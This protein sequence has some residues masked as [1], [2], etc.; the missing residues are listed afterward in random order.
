MNPTVYIVDDDDAMRD[1][2]CTL[3]DL[4]GMEA[5]A[6]ESA[7]DFLS[8]YDTDMRHHGCLVLDIRMWGMSG[9]ELQKLLGI[10]GCTLPVIIITGHGDVQ[11]T[12][13]SMKLGAME[14][15]EKPFTQDRLLECVRAAIRLSEER[16]DM[17]IQ[18]EEIQNRIARL[19]PRELEVAEI[20]I[21]G[22]S[23]KEIARQMNISSR[24]VEV[25]RAKVMFKLQ[26]DS[27]CQLVRMFLLAEGRLLTAET[28]TGQPHAC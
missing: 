18:K 16:Y 9:L 22:L 6:Y 15:I 8:H 23:N 12:V 7:L 17:N 10:R 27:L 13:K 4:A 19:S 24:T 5:K 14:F 28:Q 25:Y 26:A 20:L 21:T 2:L 3:L 1:S 11:T